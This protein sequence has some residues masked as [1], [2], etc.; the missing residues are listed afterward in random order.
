LR[1][2]EHSRFFMQYEHS[3]HPEMHY[4]FITFSEFWLVG[5]LPL[6]VGPLQLGFAP[7]GSNL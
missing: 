6:S 7:P 1:F 3:R 4:H 2:P 5:P